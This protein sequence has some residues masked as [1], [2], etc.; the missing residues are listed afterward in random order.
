MFERAI[1]ISFLAHSEYMM[2]DIHFLSVYLCE[3]ECECVHT[4]EIVGGQIFV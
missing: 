1:V 4:R 3:C 2:S